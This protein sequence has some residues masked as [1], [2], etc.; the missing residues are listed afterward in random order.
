MHDETGPEVGTLVSVRAEKWVQQGFCLGHLSEPAMP[1]F[2]HGAL[3]GEEVVAR[4]TRSNNR[5][6]FGSVESVANPAPERRASDC[7][8]FPR[9]GGCSFRH[10]DY[11]D[12]FA[13]KLKLL[14][15][16]KVLDGCRTD[17]Q[18]NG[19]FK[20]HIA[21]ADGYRTRTRLHRTSPTAYPGYYALHSNEIIPVP[22]DTGCRQLAPDLN[23]AIREECARAV[24]DATT[25]QAANDGHSSPRNRRHHALQL[26]LDDPIDVAGTPWLVPQGTFFQANQYLLPD[27]L[28]AVRGL[29]TAGLQR[30]GGASPG[31]GPRTL[32]LFCG[33][34]LLGGAVRD[35]LGEYLGY[36][37]ATDGL[38]AARSNFKARKYAGRFENTD[39]YRRPVPVPAKTGLVLVN[40]PRAGMNQ[41]QIPLIADA[42]VPL[43]LYSSCNPVTLNRDLGRFSERGYRAL[44]FE[45]FDFFPRTPHLEILILLE[46]HA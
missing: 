16:L 15:E 10:L 25:A 33:S 24:P 28:A 1:I 36:D 2:L 46:K 11:P 7:A 41:K 38:R 30:K 27:W 19:Q 3:P 8:V 21:E 42:R 12:E 23:E 14:E 43:V 40:P 35:L 45:V 20:T 39:L 29:V 6:C 32:E 17:A 13:L 26:E 44:A 31:G 37:N 22:A 18:H 9:C 34:G 5:H 4:I